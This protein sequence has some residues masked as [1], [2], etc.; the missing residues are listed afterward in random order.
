MTGLFFG[1][2]NPFHNGHLQ[3]ARYL[4][5]HR[6]TARILFVVSPRNPFKTDSSLLDE[7]K[8]LRLVETAI[9][10]DKRMEASPVEFSLPRPSYTIDTLRKLTDLYPGQDF[11]LIMGADN[12]RDF[13]LWKEY[14]TICRNFPIFVYPRPGIGNIGLHY[15]CVTQVKAPLF[16]VSSTEIRD[17]IQKGEDI[18][19]FVPPEIHTLILE[20]YS[21]PC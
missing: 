13:H 6:I 16:S 1:S 10:S 20:Y 15:P 21:K 17:K 19:A 12:L 18:S 9:A 5:D 4:L 11:A 14:E 2:F 7:T 3:I 8:R